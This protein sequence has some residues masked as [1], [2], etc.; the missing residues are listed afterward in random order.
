MKR[1]D[2]VITPQGSGRFWEYD[3]DFITVE[4]DYRYL[5]HFRKESVKR[6]NSQGSKK[7]VSSSE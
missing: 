2:H 1:G 6:D 5:V 7:T 4:M 3:G